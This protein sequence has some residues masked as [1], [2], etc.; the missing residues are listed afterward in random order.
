MSATYKKPKQGSNSQKLAMVVKH[1]KGRG[2]VVAW[3]G[4]E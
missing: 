2:V 4:G 1:K 3:R